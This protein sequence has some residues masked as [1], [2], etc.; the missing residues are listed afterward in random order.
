MTIAALYVCYLPVDEPLVQTQVV[1]YL[2]G[3]AE[4]G[5]RIHLLTFETRPHDG[6]TRSA[7]R[8]QGIS[9]HHAPYH[10]RPRLIATVIDVLAGLV[11]AST[12]TVAMSRGRR[13]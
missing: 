11:F 5:N 8:A 9:W 6:A 13:W 12:I 4:A 10:R 2:R 7:L 1:P 3:L